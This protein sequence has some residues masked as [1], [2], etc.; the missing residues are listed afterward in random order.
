MIRIS[1]T[2]SVFNSNS[3]KCPVHDCRRCPKIGQL[4]SELTAVLCLIH[5]IQIW[6]MQSQENFKLRK[7]WHN[8]LLL[9][10]EKILIGMPVVQD[11]SCLKP[12]S[13]FFNKLSNWK[14]AD[15]IYSSSVI[16]QCCSDEGRDCGNVLC[17]EMD[18]NWHVTRHNIL[19]LIFL[20]TWEMEVKSIRKEE[21]EK[22]NFRS[23]GITI[24]M[25][26]WFSFLL[27]FVNNNKTQ[28]NRSI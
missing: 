5:L 7:K 3:I 27:D 10:E 1:D 14:S 26:S 13:I 2:N 23:K 11:V 6:Q 15:T 9:Y 28:I 12:L 18:Y 19:S 20:N 22:M 8:S 25:T 4:I 24:T 21:E 17:R 16:I